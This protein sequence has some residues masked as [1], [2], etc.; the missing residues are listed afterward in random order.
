MADTYDI[1]NMLNEAKRR[2]QA[3]KPKAA[4]GVPIR[5]ILA[6]DNAA[7]MFGAGQ[8]SEIYDVLNDDGTEKFILGVNTLNA[9]TYVE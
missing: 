7:M 8:M 2:L 1:T 4:V 9:N 6:P 5:S 3:M